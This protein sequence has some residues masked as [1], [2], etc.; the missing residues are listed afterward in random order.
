MNSRAYTHKLSGWTRTI[1]ADGSMRQ[2]ITPTDDSGVRIVR[3]LSAHSWANDPNDNKADS[4]KDRVVL[5]D[6]PDLPE[7]AVQWLALAN[8]KSCSRA[9]D[10]MHAA[11]ADADFDQDRRDSDY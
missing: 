7:W 9:R 11:I 2:T 5:L 6:G 1:I 4:D 3:F 8:A 10:A